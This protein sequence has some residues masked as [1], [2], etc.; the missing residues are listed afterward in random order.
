MTVSV[1][2]IGVDFGTTTSLVS[3]GVAGRAACGAADRSYYDV[4]AVAVRP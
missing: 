1:R 3:E 4:P 2:S